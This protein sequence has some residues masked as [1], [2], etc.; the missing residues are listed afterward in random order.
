MDCLCHKWLDT[1]DK[2]GNPIKLIYGV[3]N[4]A[5]NTKYPWLRIAFTYIDEEQPSRLDLGKH[6]FGGPFT[7]EGVEDVKTLF[8]LMPL[9]VAIVGSAF[10]F[11]ELY[12]QYA[13]HAIQTTIPMVG[14]VENLQSDVIYIATIILIP[15]YQFIVYP[16]IKGYVPS[17]LKT[18]GAGI[19]VSAG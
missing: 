1:C 12:D 7:E 19:F 11:N 15:V 6:K 16:L 14:C 17:M 4:Y 18:M 8:R 9:L 2:T 13:L 5:R 3:L 10:N